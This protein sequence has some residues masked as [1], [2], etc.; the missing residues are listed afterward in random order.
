MVLKPDAALVEDDTERFR[1]AVMEQY[2]SGNLHVVIDLADV[3]FI[4]SGG[5]EALLDLAEHA[6]GA[7]G[8]LRIACL[9]DISRD[10][11]IATRIRNFIQVYGDI[12]EARKSLM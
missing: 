11:F 3:P 9:C 5:L 6:H 4:D 10:I 8:G 7:G 12:S 2:A 1:K